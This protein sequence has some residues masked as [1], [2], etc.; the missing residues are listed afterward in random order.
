MSKLKVLLLSI[1]VFLSFFGL[2]TAAQDTAPAGQLEIDAQ[3]KERNGDMVLASGNVQIYYKQIKLF[4]DYVE[5]NLETKDALARGNVVLHMPDEVLSMQEVSFNMDDRQGILQKVH[6]LVQP[7]ITYQA[8]KVERQDDSTYLMNQAWITS[9]VQTI[10]RWKFSC[11]KASFKKNDYIEMWNA[12]FR[13]KKLPVFYLPYMRYPIGDQKK[14]GFLMPQA[15]YN[16]RKG[17]VYSQAFFWNIR[18][19]MDATLNFDYFSMRGLGGGLE[20][21]Y[22][23]PN[24]IGGKLNLFYFRFNQ[25]QIEEQDTPPSAYIIRFNHNQALPLDFNLVA[26]VDY[27][28]SFD[29]LREFDNNFMRATVSNRR[30]QAYLT[31]SWSYFNL[32]MRMS[33][34]ETYFTRSQNSIIKLSKPEIS[35]NTSKIKLISPVYFSFATGFTS[36]EYGWESDYEKN[37]Q[38]KSQSFS[39]SPTITVPFTSI[40]W[41]TVNSSV[42]TNM[43]YYLQSYAPGTKEVVEEPLVSNNVTMNFELVGPVF[44]KIFF[45][46]KNEPVLK[47]IIE[48]SFIYRY[49]SPVTDSSRI[50]ATRFFFLN[51]YFKYGLV[52]RFL[53]K[54]NGMPREIISLGINQSLYMDPETS[55]LQIYDIDGRIPEYSDANIFVRFYPSRTHSVDFSSGFNPYYSTFSS[56]RLGLNLGNPTDDLFFRV[57]W[58]KSIN[59]YRVEAHWDRHQISVFSGGKFPQLNL[60]GMLEF[61]FNIYEKE[62]LYAAATLV[63]HYQCLDFKTDIRIFYFRDEPEVQFRISFGLGNIGKTTDLLGGLGF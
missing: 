49:D 35:F 43:K 62:L 22:I 26:D 47:H 52:N 2:N 4:A 31:R 20:Y 48:P 55:P 1:V 53:I 40:S 23:F 46:S 41:L 58:Y 25:Q 39:F 3:Y 34:F 29:F 17:F 18:R 10:P 12:V 30:S 38:R 5:L 21:R 8:D 37:K 6:G 33:R 9:C 51:H 54:Q 59:P 19:N 7:N 36:W 56:L 32:N 14:T 63:Y 57:N 28:S 16:G 27:Q 50:I 15:G 44:N 45:N 24:D 13:I 11:S 60:E 61:D 42:S